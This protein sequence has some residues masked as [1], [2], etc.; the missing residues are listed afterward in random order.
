MI[1][2][3][4]NNHIGGAELVKMEQGVSIM[5]AAILNGVGNIVGECGGQAMCA[6]PAT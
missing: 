6:P 4:F 3:T 5:K 1:T 2:A